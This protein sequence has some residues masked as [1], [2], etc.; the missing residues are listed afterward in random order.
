MDETTIARTESA[1]REVNEAIAKTA[2]RFDADEADFVCECADPGCAHRVTAPIDDYEDVR[3]DA[4]HFLLAPGHHE[5]E[6]ER[7]VE[8]TGEYDVVEKF[9]RTVARI[10][11]RLNPR[12]N[13]RTA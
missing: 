9:G 5:P 2:M 4:T 6:V 3:S 8:R 10:V 11:R 7:V 1:F 13:P 12:A